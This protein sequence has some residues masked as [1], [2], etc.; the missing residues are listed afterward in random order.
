MEMFPNRDRK[1]AFNL[2]QPLDF[3]LVIYEYRL[4][5]ELQYG[6]CCSALSPRLAAVGAS[7]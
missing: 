7:C 5:R 3:A 4:I 2:M 1:D 6:F